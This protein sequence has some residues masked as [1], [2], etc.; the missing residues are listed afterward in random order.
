MHYANE[1]HLNELGRTKVGTDKQGKEEFT[2]I[3]WSTKGTTYKSFMGC[4]DQGK[5]KEIEGGV[6]GSN[7]PTVAY[8]PGWIKESITTLTTGKIGSVDLS[9]EKKMQVA[10]L[11]STY[12]CSGFCTPA[13]FYFTQS[14]EKGLPE[15][16]CF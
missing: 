6:D 12:N 9:N 7:V 4:L 11:E 16:S 2:D 10:Y 5:E 1:D 15:Q 14:V 8:Q 13:L 3:V